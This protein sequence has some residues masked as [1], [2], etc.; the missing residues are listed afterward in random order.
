MLKVKDREKFKNS[1][2]KVTCHVQ[3]ELYKT[4]G[5]FLSRKFSGQKGVGSYIQYAEKK[6]SVKNT[7]LKKFFYKSD[8]E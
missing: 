6:L 4:T 2:R 1:K 5:G 3:E 7:I 8:T